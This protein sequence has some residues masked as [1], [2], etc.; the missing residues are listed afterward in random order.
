MQ[1]ADPGKETAVVKWA[2][3][4]VDLARPVPYNGTPA[5]GA[6][7]SGGSQKINYLAVLRAHWLLISCMAVVG[8]FVGAVLAVVELPAYRAATVLEITGTNE[9]FMGL[10]DFDPQA[11]GGS[12]VSN[13]QTQ[14]QILGSGSLLSR[15]ADRVTAETIPVAPPSSGF[16]SRLRTRLGRTPQDP[17]AF[18]KIAI[19]TAMNTVSARPIGASHL[20]EVSCVSESADIAAQFVNDLAVEYVSQN[21][22]LRVRSAT[23]TSQWLEGQ[24]EETRN[25]LDDAQGK[26]E[27]FV[28]SKGLQFVLDQSTLADT[29]LR[30]LQSDLSSIQTD[31]IGKQSRFEIAKS[32][33][34][35]SLPDILDDGTLRDLRDQV[36]DLR[37]QRAEL[38]TTLTP[39]HIKVQRVDAQIRDLQATMEKEK[40]D[41][42]KRMQDEYEAALRQER[43]LSAAYN[44]Q[45]MAVANDSDKAGEYN[46]LKRDVDRLQQSYNS[47][48]QEYNQVSMAAAV[49]AGNVRVIDAAAPYYTP[50]KPK[51]VQY[52]AAGAGFGALA[53]IVL[54]IL[55]ELIRF[56]KLSHVFASPGQLTSVLRLPELGVIPTF[57]QGLQRRRSPTLGNHLRNGVPDRSRP[58]VALGKPSVLTDSFRHTLTSILARQVAG[59][60]VV[61]VVTSVGPQEGKTTTI[62]NLA[63][64]TAETGRKVL[65][66]DADLRRPRLRHIF[67]LEAG[68]GL[69]DLLDHELPANTEGWGTYIVNTPVAG[70]S[71]MREGTGTP[72]SLRKQSFS[73]RLTDLFARLKEMYDVVLVDTPPAALCPDARLF[74]LVADGVILVIRS[75][76]TFRESAAAIAER[77]AEDGA[78]VIGTILNGWNPKSGSYDY[79]GYVYA[80]YYGTEKER[81]A[82]DAAS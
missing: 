38:L 68:E 10:K 73:P 75:G 24:I 33:P 51:P 80:G 79:P 7:A 63:A 66:I 30:Q 70:L 55:I 12:D 65:L 60:R 5:G 16:V 29:K 47:L 8:V 3:T 4:A 19:Q 23:Q 48:L 22:Q 59:S 18:T 74:G 2:K 11:G 81:A 34:I 46:L 6:A 71:L 52:L 14:L 57:E 27:A 40:V 77:F 61:L 17:A 42:V 13:I 31:R 1:Q 62:A 58:L 44:A 43:L 37:R 72:E 25:R 20:V 82:N 41:L 54:S 39:E 28:K 15:V 53:A 50:F 35:D 69:T 56:R 26:L 45:A 78:A 49:P 9:S 64:A 76:V 67:G 36:T 21:V 32:S